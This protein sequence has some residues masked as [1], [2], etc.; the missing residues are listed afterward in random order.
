ML[1]WR[2]FYSN[3]SSFCNEDGE[4]FEAP[5]TGALVIVQANESVGRTLLRGRDYYWF[6][7][8]RWFGGDLAGLI[9]Y[10]VEHKGPQKI[11]LGKFVADETFHSV[12]KQALDDP[13]FEPKSAWCS[14]DDE[15]SVRIR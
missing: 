6:E 2:I 11:I 4:V 1:A 15:P 10:L 13:D 5:A 9:L 3:G 8:D 14:E 7:N 12:I